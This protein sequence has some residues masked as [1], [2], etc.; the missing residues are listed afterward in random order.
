MA[1]ARKPVRA[2]GVRLAAP[3]YCWDM[4]NYYLNP[5]V[6]MLEDFLRTPSAGATFDYG[7]S[8]KGHGWHPGSNAA[9]VKMMAARWRTGRPDRG[10]RTG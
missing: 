6:Y 4:G 10:A 2:V 7:W 8:M 5:A 1:A 9:L 3:L